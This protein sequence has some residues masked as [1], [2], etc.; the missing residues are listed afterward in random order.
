METPSWSKVINDIIETRLCELHTSMPG[1]VV[2]YDKS[3]Q[4]ANIKP[5]L[6][7]S[8][9]DG[10]KVELPVI[11]NVPVKWPR[12][13]LAYMHF[14]LKE[15]EPVAVFFI[16][17]SIDT[18]KTSGG[19]ADP[20]SNRKHSLSDAFC[21]P[22]LYPFSNPAAVDDGDSIEIG[23][24]N[25][26]MNMYNDGKFSIKHLILGIEYVEQSLK[27]IDE[28][29]LSKVAT[30]LGLQSLIPSPSYLIEKLKLEEFKK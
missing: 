30:M 21:V 25:F 19:L 20:E 16:E 17:R 1:E 10:R 27:V 8:Y 12:S 24:A 18:W 28:V 2:S 23:F 13:G 26:L 3:V 29:M 22:G 4:K 11:N 5:L 15:G 6:K 14:P 9:K 7:R